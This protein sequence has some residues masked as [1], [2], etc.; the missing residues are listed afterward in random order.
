MLPLNK[1]LY[2]HIFPVVCSIILFNCFVCEVFSV[3]KIEARSGKCVGVKSCC[4]GV[5]IVKYCCVAL[6]L[7]Y[8]TLDNGLFTLGSVI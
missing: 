7:V 4:F 2:V 6:E 5:G 8:V 1:F 3:G